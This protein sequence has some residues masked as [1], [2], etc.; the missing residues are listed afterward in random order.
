[1]KRVQD[2]HLHNG[3]EW[4]GGYHIVTLSFAVALGRESGICDTV[5]D[6]VNDTYN[7]STVNDTYNHSTAISYT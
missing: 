1:M 5:D 7:H 6:T 2:D 4:D 3:L